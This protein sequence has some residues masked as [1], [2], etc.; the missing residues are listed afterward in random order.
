MAHA[1]MFARARRHRQAAANR[2][3][4]P[5]A[6]EEVGAPNWVFS[7]LASYTLAACDV[8]PRFAYLLFVPQL[9]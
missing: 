2:R 3:A 6:L 9:D 4:S 1:A 8:P 7:N 5:T